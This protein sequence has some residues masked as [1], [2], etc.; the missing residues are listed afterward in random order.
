MYF[1]WTIIYIPFAILYYIKAGYT[2]SD[3]LREYINDFIFTGETPMAWHM[4]YMHT[5]IISILILW[6]LSYIKLGI[7]IIFTLV[8]TVALFFDVIIAFDIPILMGVKRLVENGQNFLLTGLPTIC[9]G[10]LIKK[11]FIKFQLSKQL[12]LS[13]SI[14]AIL[15]CLLLYKLHIHYYC[16][17][18]SALIFIVMMKINQVNNTNITLLMGECSKYVYFLHLIVAFALR[19]K[20]D[21]VY[22]YW[23]I[24]VVISMILSIS[25]YYIKRQL[26]VGTNTSR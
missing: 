8:F 1:V 14:I 18:L 9:L 26:F 22:L 17:I 13:I 6:L 16:I 25:L 3:A 10:A 2:I 11:C 19:G 24:V 5:L 23:I 12:M 4:W 20:I 15:C 7:D 21:S